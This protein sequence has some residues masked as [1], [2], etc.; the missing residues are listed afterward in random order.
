MHPSPS[1][2]RFPLWLELSGLPEKVNEVAKA[3]YAWGV[4]RKV[5]ELDMAANALRPGLVETPPAELA[6]RCGLDEKKLD[7][8]VKGLRKAGV[9]RAFLPDHGEE[10]ALFQVITPV[11]TPLTP[12][13][14]RAAHPELFVEAL[15]PPRYAV[16]VPEQGDT[17]G[18]ELRGEEKV[19]RVVELYLNTF[20]MRLNSIILDQLQ[21]M[22]SHYDVELLE[23]IFQ[24]A[25]KREARSLGWVLTEIRREVAA[26]RLN[27]GRNRPG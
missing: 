2:A 13:D 20:S 17:P 26:E 21:L 27:R 10:S 5:V 25:L 12:D 1:E 3:P 11:P 14:V 19:R 7:K 4:F 23:R 24:R 9:L 15:W 22:A 8:A 6:A 18:E 16:E